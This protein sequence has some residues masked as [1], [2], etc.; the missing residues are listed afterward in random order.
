MV[1]TEGLRD[2]EVPQT[3]KTAMIKTRHFWME[4][5]R[6]RKYLGVKKKEC[7]RS[8]GYLFSYGVE[9]VSALFNLLTKSWSSILLFINFLPWRYGMRFPNPKMLCTAAN[10]ES[11][12]P[13]LCFQNQI[14]MSILHIHK[15]F[16]AA[17]K[18]IATSAILGTPP[19][20]D[21]APLPCVSSE[22]LTLVLPVAVMPFN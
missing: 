15:K 8:R 17:T 20:V 4:R 12:T 3:A 11:Q 10:E 18:A 21:A 19:I 7:S 2:F 22:V 14:L 13:S 5:R 6:T 1:D 16:A 9:W